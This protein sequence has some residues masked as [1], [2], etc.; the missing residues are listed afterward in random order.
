M[1]T[2]TPERSQIDNNDWC[3]ELIRSFTTTTLKHNNPFVVVR[4]HLQHSLSTGR[5]AT[6]LTMMYW[7]WYNVSWGW[8]NSGNNRNVKYPWPY[9]LSPLLLEEATSVV[10]SYLGINEEWNPD[11]LYNRSVGHFLILETLSCSL[12]S[13]VFKKFL[14]WLVFG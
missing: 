8:I 3:R 14:S 9:K 2:T 7:L 1:S 13:S 12:E 10:M 4:K 5:T 11:R 6:L